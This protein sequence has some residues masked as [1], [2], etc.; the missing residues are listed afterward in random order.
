MRL[1][2]LRRS[3][4]AELPGVVGTVR[5][6]RRTK[7]LTKRL[8]PGDIAV[9]EHLD[10][11]RVS[12]E[13]LVAARVGMVINTVESIS[14]R[15]PNLGPEILIEAGIPL[16]DAAGTDLF[17]LLEEGQR[18]RVDDG[19][20]YRGQT[21]IATGAV[22]DATTVA[23]AM[24]DSWSHLAGTTRSPDHKQSTPR[25]G[26]RDASCRRLDAARD[27]ARGSAARRP[28]APSRSAMT[29]SSWPRGG[30][31]MRR[32]C[33]L[34]S[35][36]GPAG[37]RSARACYEHLGSCPGAD[38]DARDHPSTGLARAVRPRSGGRQPGA[39]RGPA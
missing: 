31:T 21:L 37:S 23:A 20:L 19:A 6:D 24:D 18:V 29:R 22:H 11:D 2:T 38:R 13:A 9:I 15:Y 28:P 16:V 8:A 33:W 12:A 30:A 3:R 35:P 34:R 36:L 17:G 26:Q 25:K 39:G 4:P 14:G 5:L 7:N 32:C 27:P 10:L 1:P